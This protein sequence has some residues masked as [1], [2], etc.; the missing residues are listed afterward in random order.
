M[1]GLLGP[2]GAGKS[3]TLGCLTTLMRPTRGR[4][5]VDGIDVAVDDRGGR[6]PLAVVP[7]MRNLDRDL[8]VREM[9]PFHG[10]YFGMPR[11]AR[12]ARRRPARELQLEDKAASKPATLSGGLQQRG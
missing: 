2:N 11:R 1:F 9:L 3:T 6:A 7:Q 10:G 12:S 5:E 4:I 8:T